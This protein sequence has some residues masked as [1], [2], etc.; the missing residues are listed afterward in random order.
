MA[1]C[2]TFVLPASVPTLEPWRNGVPEIGSQ[3]PVRNVSLMIAYSSSAKG[4]ARSP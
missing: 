2:L 4:N 1:Q 3:G